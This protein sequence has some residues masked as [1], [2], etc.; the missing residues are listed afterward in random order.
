MKRMVKGVVAV[1]L[2]SSMLLS[3]T[4]CG[5][6][7]GEQVIAAANDY[8]KAMID[9]DVD[10][11]EEMSDGMDDDFKSTLADNYQVDAE[12]YGEDY[13]KICNAITDTISYEVDEES[14]DASTKDE[15]GSVDVVFTMVDYTKIAE[16][17]DA[18]SDVDT[19]VSALSDKD[20]DTKEI[21]VTI[22]FN[23]DDEDW[24]VSN[25]D[26]ILQATEEDSVLY[27]YQDAFSIKFVPAYIDMIDYTEWY[28]TDDGE[29][30]Y[31][32]PTGIELDIV[33]FWEF[34]GSDYVWEFYYEV[35]DG[36][37]TLIYTSEELSDYGAWIEAYFYADDFDGAL[38]DDVYLPADSYT[39]TFFDLDGNEI[40]SSTCTVVND[41]SSSSASGL[42]AE[43]FEDNVEREFLYD[44]RDASGNT[45]VSDDG[46][47]YLSNVTKAEYTI[48]V[49][50]DF[51]A[52]I[53]YEYYYSADGNVDNASLVYSA[54][55]NPTVYTDG[56]FY[57]CSYTCDPMPTGTYYVLGYD[58]ESMDQ[59]LFTTSFTVG[60]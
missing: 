43:V 47:S 2:T 11:L 41:S 45:T 44:Y 7:A 38:V 53:Y 12:T 50:D 17:E 58:S 49:A 26:D 46:L 13:E 10:T 20:A 29:S 27:Y 42:T 21:T 51:D 32:D 57:E 18:M 59:L 30:T 9:G 39:I 25:F 5:D 3:M 60:A 1:A 35:Y 22:E 16:D 14:V 24:L 33:P 34:Q 28:Y 52:S 15:E 31:T 56:S 55:I 37:D 48:K 4:A 40:A 19:F 23:L 6:K 8:A 54:T 36:T